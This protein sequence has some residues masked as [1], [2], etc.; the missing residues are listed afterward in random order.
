[1]PDRSPKEGISELAYA[2]AL[3]RAT[4]EATADGVLAIDETAQVTTWNNKFLEMWQMP[5]EILAEPGAHRVCTF[6]AQQLKDPE[7]Y[8]SRIVEI[9]ASSS[10][11]FDL[12]ELADGRQIE[13]YS[14]II[15]VGNRAA[16]RVWSFRDVTERNRSDLISRRLAAIVDN[17]DMQLLGRT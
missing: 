8:R 13:R 6:I 17:S 10:K 2:L 4:L 9:E 11:S 15:S 16:G 12:L 5:P 1:M 14:E 3:T 7:A